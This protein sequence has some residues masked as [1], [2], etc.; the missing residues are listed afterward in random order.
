V[1]T[2][3]YSRITEQII[4]ELERGVRPW[5]KP[6]DAAHAA[7]PV[8]RPLRANGERYNGMNILM[9][10]VAAMEKG[11]NA[12]IWM[13]FRQ[14]R[15]LGGHVRKGEK[16]SLVVYA[17]TITRTETDEITGEE[18]DREIPFMKGYTVFNVDQTDGL[19]AHYYARAEHRLNPEQRLEQ[20]ERFFAT[21]GAEIR[22]GG[23]I[24]CYVPATD[25]IRMPP[26]ESF[27]SAASFYATLGHE[28][29]HW[30]QHP[31][32][33]DRDLGRKRFGDHSYAM[34]ELVA[35][36][37]AAFLCADLELTPEIRND[38]AP[39]LAGWLKA[40]RD[41]KRAIFTAAA[42]AQRAVDFL[43][44]AARCSE[45]AAAS[46]VADTVPHAVACTA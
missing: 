32:R 21:L 16:G 14:A 24:A 15:A 5:H 1:K 17:N 42:H 30:T 37:G 28:T 3:V 22:H 18:T 29:V 6:W 19:P 38:H 11:F 23:N 41:D 13:T 45:P 33:L 10:W 20:A 25:I 12:P 43:S 44:D 7:G 34:E 36:I 46:V 9:L 4:A 40:L 39:Y 2:D 27:R 8:S 26:F 31:S 35:E